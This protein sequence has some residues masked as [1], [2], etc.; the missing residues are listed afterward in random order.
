MQNLVMPVD[1][2]ISFPERGSAHDHGKE[3]DTHCEHI[4]L[5]WV[6]PQSL[7]YLQIQYLGGHVTESP[8]ASEVE[9]VSFDAI[10][11]GSKSEVCNLQLVVSVEQ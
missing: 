7:A 5:F 3:N 6:V 1:E 2:R 4:C 11:L 10:A 8:F 9:E